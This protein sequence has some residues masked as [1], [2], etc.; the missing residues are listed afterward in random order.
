MD[1]KVKEIAQQLDC[2]IQAIY[3]KKQ[4]LLDNAMAYYDNNNNF[5]ITVEGLNY[6]KE[7][8]SRYFESQGYKPDATNKEKI[9]QQANNKRDAELQTNS[10]YERIIEEKDRTIEELRKQI[11][12]LQKDKD[13]QAMQIDNLIIKMLP[14]P[15]EKKSIFLKIFSNKKVDGE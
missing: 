5:L 4:F 9:I 7:K 3:K 8:R 14:P 11:E 1:F 2:S 13:R 12:Y 10:F 6:L 15:P